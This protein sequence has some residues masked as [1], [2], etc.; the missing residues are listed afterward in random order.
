MGGLKIPFDACISFF[1]VLTHCWVF[2]VFCMHVND[3]YEKAQLKVSMCSRPWSVEVILEGQ[4]F[5]A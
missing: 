3:K 5:V 2:M 1:S 4:Q